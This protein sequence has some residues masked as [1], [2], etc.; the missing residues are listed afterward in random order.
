[1]LHPKVLKPGT[2]DILRAILSIEAFDSFNLVG[3][4]ALALQFGHRLS[5]DLDFFTTE[6]FDKELAKIELDGIGHWVTDGENKISLRGQLNGVKIDFVTYRYPLLEAISVIEGV[7][8]LSQADISAMKLAAV[9]NRGAKKDFYD[10]FF[11]LRHYS[12]AQL[13]NWYQA[14]FQTNNLFMLLKSLT[15]FDD[16]ELTETP[17]ILADNVSWEMVK[18]TILLEVAAYS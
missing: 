18:H 11:L 7:R 2:L 9:T 4:T 15:Y 10:I 1:M 13:C 3:G 6:H 12:F 14:K 17:I 16:A 5:I 8:M